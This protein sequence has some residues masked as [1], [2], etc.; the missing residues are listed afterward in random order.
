MYLLNLD[1]GSYQDFAKLESPV[2]NGLFL[3]PSTTEMWFLTNKKHIL[4]A[5]GAKFTTE[6]TQFDGTGKCGMI[7]NSDEFISTNKDTIIKVNIQTG[8]QEL[9]FQGTGNMD[10]CVINPAGIYL[11]VVDQNG[12]GQ[13]ISSNYAQRLNAARC[14]FELSAQQEAKPIEVADGKVEKVAKCQ[15]PEGSTGASFT[16]I[17]DSNTI[18]VRQGE[19]IHFI[20][21]SSQ[22]IKKSVKTRLYEPVPTALFEG[23]LY[24]LRSSLVTVFDLEKPEDEPQDFEHSKQFPDMFDHPSYMQFESKLMVQNLSKIFIFDLI[25]RQ[26]KTLDVQICSE[27][28]VNALLLVQSD[29]TLSFAGANKIA[30][31]DTD[32]KCWE[33]KNCNENLVGC[34]GGML[35]ED[36]YLAIRQA[37]VIMGNLSEPAQIMFTGND[38]TQCAPAYAGQYMVLTD[39]TGEFCVFQSPYFQQLQQFKPQVLYKVK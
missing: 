31:V 6:D 13:I 32:K 11:V 33:L 21:F 9:V 37:Q 8:E 3:H 10:G 2:E 22:T 23:K 1:N 20:E 18:I 5:N 16:G 4:H 17:L 38:M 26:W 19:F 24:E 34:Y 39:A 12:L 30:S 36:K 27:N 7:L 25:T 28:L 14:G 15:L 29:H 35:S